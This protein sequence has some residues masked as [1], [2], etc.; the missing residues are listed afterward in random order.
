MVFDHRPPLALR[1]VG[2][3][4]NDPDRLAAICRACDARKTPSDL[5]RIAKAKRQASLH[6]DHAERMSYR[7]CGRAAPSRKEWR[8]MTRLLDGGGRRDVEPPRPQERGA[9]DRV[10]PEANGSSLPEAHCN[11][12]DD[13]PWQSRLPRGSGTR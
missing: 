11:S 9:V 3:D 6:N 4:P 8:A 12:A 13:L 1:D 7:V 2:D 5:A 10:S